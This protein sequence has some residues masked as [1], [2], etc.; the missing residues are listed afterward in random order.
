M[1][2]GLIDDSAE[3]G[4]LTYYAQAD[5]I[6]YTTHNPSNMMETKEVE[7]FTPKD[8]G[9]RNWGREVLIA[10]VPGLYT[11]KL[12]MYNRGARGGLQKHHLK[13]ECSYIYSGEMM[14]YYDAGDG[15]ISQKKLVA[16]DSVHIPP[17][18]VH[19]EE[20]ITDLVIFETSTPHFND[21]VRMEEQ[22]GEEIPVGGLPST[23]ID[24]VE[25][26]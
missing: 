5:I 9:P 12:L 13:D 6:D 7:F 20:A 2:Y 25:T 19:R 21:R 3:F 23:T 10:H 15:K 16:G 11:G 14:F 26:R 17:G 1:L 22:Y 4:A 24:Q 18:A 8:V